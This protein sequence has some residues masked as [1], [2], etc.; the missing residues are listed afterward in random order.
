MAE[1]NMDAVKGPELKVH[2]KTLNESGLLPEEIVVRPGRKNVDLAAEFVAGIEATNDIGKLD[3]VPE[4]V[5]TYYTS[6]VVPGKKKETPPAEPKT[7]GRGRGKAATPPADDKKK[8]TGKKA[9][10]PPA[11]AAKKQTRADVFAAIVKGSK[12]NLDKAAIEEAM[13]NQYEGSTKET[14]FWVSCYLRLCLS[15][16]VMVKN[17]DKTYSWT[18]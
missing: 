4:E 14:S 16:G 2:I 18:G 11:P 13:E 7:T 3:D 10:A 15:L 12:G 1:I 5:F 17:D 9:T 8:A 6:I